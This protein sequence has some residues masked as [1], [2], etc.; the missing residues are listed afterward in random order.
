T[1]VRRNTA[2]CKGACRQAARDALPSLLNAHP[3]L[4]EVALR[5][6]A[7]TSQVE[8]LEPSSISCLAVD[9]W[10]PQPH[11]AYDV[12]FDWSQ[13]CP[14]LLPALLLNLDYTPHTGIS[15]DAQL[16]LGGWLCSHVR[17]LSPAEPDDWCWRV[18]RALRLHR[19][20]WGLRPEAPPP[21]PEPDDLFSKAYA[22]MQSSWGHCIPLICSSGVAALC[23]LAAARA[24]DAV[25]CLAPLML[26]LVDSPESVASTTKFTDLFSLIMGGG[27]L[28]AR[29]LGR[30]SPGAALL[31]RLVHEQLAG[32]SCGGVPHSALV[33]VWICALW[34]P[35]PGAAALLDAALRPRDLWQLNEFAQHQVAYKC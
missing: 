18:L 25:H 34:R 24:Q 32:D 4:Y 3:H 6:V 9:R 35:A 13:R 20:C 30:G 14:H 16:G 15:L 1:G 7:D 23:S 28:V 31:A 11:E 29:A 22:L 33:R 27:G 5:H 12:A 10:R 26:V 19:A 2:S 21:D 17:S 8:K